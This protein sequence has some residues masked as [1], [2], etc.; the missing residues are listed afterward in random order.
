MRV[1]DTIKALSAVRGRLAENY[2]SRERFIN[3]PNTGGFTD[4]FRPIAGLHY[5][6]TCSH[7]SMF[8][9]YH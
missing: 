5:C 1:I 9:V 8:L 7:Q 2:R 6:L 4:H 3:K